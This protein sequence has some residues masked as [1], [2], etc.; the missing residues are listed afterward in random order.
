VREQQTAQEDSQQREERQLSA[1]LSWLENA[2]GKKG[3]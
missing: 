2:E 3:E 1:Y